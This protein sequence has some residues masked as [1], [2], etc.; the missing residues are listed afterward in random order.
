[1]PHK[2]PGLQE[3]GKREMVDRE[4][5]QGVVPDNVSH[6]QSLV[7]DTDKGLVTVRRRERTT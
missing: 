3:R 5:P 2:T 1:M 7:I 4:A 6:E